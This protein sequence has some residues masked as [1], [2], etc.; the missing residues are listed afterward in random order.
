MC[1]AAPHPAPP[2]TLYLPNQ[3]CC[4]QPGA[5]PCGSSPEQLPGSLHCFRPFQRI[6]LCEG[7]SD[8]EV[9]SPLHE[10][11]THSLVAMEFSFQSLAGLGSG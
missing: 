4:L 1:P 2:R 8:T 6:W 9:A 11:Y 7:L 5:P 10:I 3:Q